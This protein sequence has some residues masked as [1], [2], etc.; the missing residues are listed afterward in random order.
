[1]EYL[2]SQIKNNINFS[3]RISLKE[4]TDKLFGSKILPY[5][6]MNGIFFDDQHLPYKIRELAFF[7]AISYKLGKKE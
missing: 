6:K 3:L 2:L 1:M 4:V 5:Y 7:K